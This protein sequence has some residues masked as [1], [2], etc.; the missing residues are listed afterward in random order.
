MSPY[1]EDLDVFFNPDEF[2]D[3][4]VLHP[5]EP[6]ERVAAAIFD[7]PYLAADPGGLVGDASS[8]P[9]IT[10]RAEDLAAVAQGDCLTIN[11]DEFVVAQPPQPD[12]S[13]CM[14]LELL[15]K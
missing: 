13:G 2:G 6:G 1:S 10:G 11:G 3:V 15:E 5:G 12:G 8:R 7:R 4:V 14:R 9:A